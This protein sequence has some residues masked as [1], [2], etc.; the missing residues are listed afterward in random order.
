M[1]KHY[2]YIGSN[3]VIALANGDLNE[4]P[5]LLI[6]SCNSNLFSNHNKCSI[7]GDYYSVKVFER[8]SS[9]FQKC[10]KS[11]TCTVQSGPLRKGV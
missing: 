8:F 2:P 6:I 10:N 1:N 4:I 11:L 3:V 7:E 5:T 9:S